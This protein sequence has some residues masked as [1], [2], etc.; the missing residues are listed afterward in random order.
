VALRFRFTTESQ[1][2]IPN[3]TLLWKLARVI[4]CTQD[5]CDS[6]ELLAATL[7]TSVI[8][9]VFQANDEA[10]LQMAKDVVIVILLIFPNTVQYM[11][12]VFTT[13]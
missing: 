10:I 2:T 3:F 9:I 1:T 13:V 7:Q 5:L 11:Y 8:C 6:F 4:K 12:S